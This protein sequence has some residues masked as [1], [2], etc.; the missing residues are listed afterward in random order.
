MTDEKRRRTNTD[1]AKALRRREHSK[2]VKVLP[3]PAGA[4]NGEG[5]TDYQRP[6]TRSKKSSV[7]T[8]ALL[9]RQAHVNPPWAAWSHL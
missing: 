7:A 1:G 9:K 8:R 5:F 2:Q 3:V 4:R 6:G